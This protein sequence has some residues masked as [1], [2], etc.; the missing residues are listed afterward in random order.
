MKNV[1]NNAKLIHNDKGEYPLSSGQKGLWFLHQINPLSA[2]YNVPVTFKITNDLELTDLEKLLNVF[3]NRHTLMHSGFYLRN[4]QP[5]RKILTKARINLDRVDVSL[6]SYK[7]LCQNI[8]KQT[9]SAFDLQ[10]APLLRASVLDGYKSSRI[11]LLVFHHLVFDGASL[12]LLI[13]ELNL[14]HQAINAETTDLPALAFDFHDYTEW[15]QQWLRSEDSQPSQQFWLQQLAG[16]IP[17]LQL[18]LKKNGTAQ[19][20]IRGEVKKFAVSSHIREKFQQLATEHKCSEFLLWL[21]AYFAF[22][23]RYT[24]QKDII[25]GNPYMGRADSRFDKIIGFFANIAPIRCQFNQPESFLQLL[26]RNKDNVYN[27]LFHGDY[28]IEEL[29]SQLQLPNQ[30]ADELLFQTAFV[31]TQAAEINKIENNSLGLEVL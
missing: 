13:D 10:Q 30:K 6:L 26:N 11:L 15:Q 14:I 16:E 2:R 20:T 24:L 27:S 29:I 5:I 8:K 3:I 4:G 21:M 25:I 28:P 23:S 31:W 18:P 9:E 1:E 22:L 17:R 19:E 12:K 7:E